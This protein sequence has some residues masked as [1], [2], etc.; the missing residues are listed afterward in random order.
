MAT[1]MASSVWIGM[2]VP[3]SLIAR[4]DLIFNSNLSN[5]DN[6]PSGAIMPCGRKRKRA[7]MKK[8]KLKKRRKKMR[9]SKR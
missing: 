9:H 4:K 7:K 1:A 5:L 6:I 8:H 3:C 2:L